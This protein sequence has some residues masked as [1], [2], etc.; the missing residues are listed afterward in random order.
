MRLIDA[1]A[2]DEEMDKLMKKYTRMGRK[3]LSKITTL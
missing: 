2:M 3:K 1:D